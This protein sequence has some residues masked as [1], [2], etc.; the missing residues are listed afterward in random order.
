MDKFRVQCPNCKRISFMT[1]ESYDPD[2]KPNG[3]MVKNLL[4]YQIDW[5]TS[6]S[7]SAVE[8]TCP[9]C[10][11]QL[12]VKDRLVVLE[13]DMVKEMEEFHKVISPERLMNY[14]K[15]EISN[16]SKND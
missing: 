12:T 15:E 9:E 13:P 11:A 8:M 16:G 4:P 6:R 1:T 5:L 3:S 10:L 14:N 2:V 7:T